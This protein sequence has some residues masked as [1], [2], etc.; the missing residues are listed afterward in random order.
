M[1]AGTGNG[2]SIT[3]SGITSAL[4]SITSSGASRE[5]IETTHLGTTGEKTFSPGD[6]V[7]EGGFSVEGY[8]D[9]TEAP[10][11]SAAAS[12]VVVVPS[13]STGATKTFTGSGFVTGWEWGASLDELV[14]FSA[15]IK[16]AG[17]VTCT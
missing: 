15:T 17:S 3:I 5:S 10:I 9:G 11:S 2:A 16:W 13:S 12:M 1:A 8:W 14:S 7:D 4:T 6:L